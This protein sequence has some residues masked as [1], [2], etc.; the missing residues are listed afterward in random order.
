[1]INDKKWH[2]SVKPGFINNQPKCKG[3]WISKWNHCDSIYLFY[4]RV[5]VVNA[6]DDNS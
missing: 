1:M 4:L 2:M 3:V 5:Q 6:V